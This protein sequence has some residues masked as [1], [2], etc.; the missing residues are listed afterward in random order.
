MVIETG[1]KAELRAHL[2]RLQEARVDESMIRIDT[3]CRRPVQQSTYQLSRFVPNPSHESGNEQRRTGYRYV[4]PA[5]LKTL[6][7]PGGEGHSVRSPTDFDEWASLRE[8]E[9]WAEPFTFV[10]DGTGTLRLASR[11]SEH[12]TCAG[13][14]KVLSA[15]E[16]SFQHESGKWTVAEVSNQST[17]YCPD[18]SSWP[19]VAEALDRVGVSRPSG[20]THEVVFRRCSSC[21][22]IN[23]V[24]E[25]DFVCA[26]CNEV[27]PQD[28][29]VDRLG[30]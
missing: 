8:A 23:I 5:D 22:Q 13:G 7:R 15:G 16:I 19:A 28:W 4:G 29:N 2:R 12:V 21:Q 18:G 27:L 9:E 10:V 11:R 14:K 24:R 30:P 1:D 26:F 20:F 3:L 6:I 17:G 25:A